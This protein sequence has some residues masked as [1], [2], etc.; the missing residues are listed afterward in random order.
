M[1]IKNPKLN[2]YV[3][4][5]TKRSLPVLVKHEHGD[6]DVLE[7][8]KGMCEYIYDDCFDYDEYISEADVQFL[9]EGSF[10]FVFEHPDNSNKVIKLMARYKE[11][12]S[13]YQYLRLCKDGA[14]P[15]DW[16]PNV[17]AMGRLKL[18]LLKGDFVDMAYVVLDRL[19]E[20]YNRWDDAR[21][22]TTCNNSRGVQRTRLG[23]V[24]SVC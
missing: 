12:T 24:F 19:E 20:V 11:D 7:H 8:I 10:S 3:H 13:C 17:H 9:G 23:K 15:F 5:K 2:G 22:Y 1:K 14:I 16:I 6:I 4:L 21:L 18:A